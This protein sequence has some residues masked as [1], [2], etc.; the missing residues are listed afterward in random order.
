MVFFSR[1]KKEDKTKSSD[2]SKW[3]S[4]IVSHSCF[5]FSNNCSKVNMEIFSIHKQ[6]KSNNSITLITL[7]IRSAM[8]NGLYFYS[9]F[10]VLANHWKP[11]N[12]SQ[13]S[14]FPT[15][16]CKMPPAHQEG[17]WFETHTLTYRWNSHWIHSLIYCPITLWHA[18]WNSQDRKHQPS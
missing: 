12:T 5:F 6:F 18:V 7:S 14:P 17:Y 11:Y 13:H 8:V 2:L 16:V 4:C 3:F 1:L 9:N 10:L 15:H